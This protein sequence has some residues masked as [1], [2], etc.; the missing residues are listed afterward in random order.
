M[1]CDCT[2]YR[3]SLLMMTCDCTL[4]RNP[5]LI[6]DGVYLTDT[7]YTYVGCHKDGEKRDLPNNFGQGTPSNPMTPETCSENCR[8]YIMFGLQVY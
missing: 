1:T 3:N 6:S 2:L 7:N 4:Y 5:L 8:D